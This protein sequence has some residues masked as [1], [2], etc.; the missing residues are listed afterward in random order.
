M[1]AWSSHIGRE[2]IDNL[3]ICLREKAFLGWAYRYR[4]R[5]SSSSKSTA[6]LFEL[7]IYTPQFAQ[8]GV[9]FSP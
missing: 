2:G 1:G 3:S 4:R 8:E 6:I 7:S 5:A 9:A